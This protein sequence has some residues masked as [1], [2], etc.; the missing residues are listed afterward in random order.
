[1]EQD[2]GL[3]CF[4]RTE[5]LLERLVAKQHPLVHSLHEGASVGAFFIALHQGGDIIRRKGDLVAVLGAQAADLHQ[6]CTVRY[7]VRFFLHF[8]AA[9]QIKDQAQAQRVQLRAV[10]LTGELAGR[11]A[12]PD[13]APLDM[14]ALVGFVTAQL[15][16]VGAAG[17]IQLGAGHRV[18]RCSLC[19]SAGQHR[20]IVERLCGPSAAGR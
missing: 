13:L 10:G 17:K 3:A 1:M 16:E 7:V 15:P 19:R 4:Q 11:D 9:A 14:L 18:G 8:P 20:E 12:A 2:G 5:Q 6:T